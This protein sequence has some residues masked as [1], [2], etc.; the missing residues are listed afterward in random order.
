MQ[1]DIWDCVTVTIY[2]SLLGTKR[3]GSAF[4]SNSSSALMWEPRIIDEIKFKKAVDTHF[5]GGRPRGSN[6]F[7]VIRLANTDQALTPF[8]T[9]NYRDA[10]LVI[11]RGKSNTAGVSLS[12]VAS[13]LID[14]I[15]SDG[16]DVIVIYT[17][18]NSAKLEVAAQQNFYPTTVANRALHNR[19]RP[20]GFGKAFQCAPVE[21][22]LYGNRSYDIH[23]NEFFIGVDQYMDQGVTLAP[24]DQSYANGTANDLMNQYRPRSTISGCYGVDRLDAIRGRQVISAQLQS[25]YTTAVDH[26]FSA[27]TDWTET[28]GGVGG[29]DASISGGKL[30]FVN[31]TGG[32]DLYI[33]HNTTQTSSES[34]LWLCIIDVDSVT[35]GEFYVASGTSG[36]I[37]KIQKKGV[38]RFTFRTTANFAPYIIAYNGSNCS[39]VIN[40]FKLYELSLIKN[41][42]GIFA[43]LC[44]YDDAS[45]SG[46]GPLE[47]ASLDEAALNALPTYSLGAYYTEPVQIADV[48]DDV[49]QSLGGWWFI[50]N[51]GLL[52][53]AQLS[54]P[55]AGVSVYS[56]DESNVSSDIEVTP[57]TA[58]GLS[59]TILA[60]KNWTPYGQG[61]VAES[62]KYVQWNP[63][64]KDT[65]VTL[66]AEANPSGIENDASAILNVAAATSSQAGSVRSM[67]F[68]F[69]EKVYIEVAATSIPSASDHWRFGPAGRRAS[70]ASAPGSSQHSIGYGNSGVV[71]ANNNT[72]LSGKLTYTTG[73]TVS[74]VLD[75]RPCARGQGYLH[76]AALPGQSIGGYMFY[77]RNNSWNDSD[78]NSTE[79]ASNMKW[80]TPANCGY[81]MN[82]FNSVAATGSMTVNFGQKA[83]TYTPPDDCFLP[84]HHFETITSEYRYTYQSSSTIDPFYSQAE[85]YGT[86][87]E[88]KGTPT[89]ITSMADARTECERWITDLYPTGTRRKFYKFEGLLLDNYQDIQP[90]D[91]IDLTSSK[92]NLSALK[93]VVVEVEGNLIEGK[94]N[95]KGWA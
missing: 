92:L 8:L 28:N 38:H 40:S 67:P 83:L 60:L 6:T 25:Y 55:S 56:F 88:R 7:G 77:A 75:M 31:T 1:N 39:V 93:M 10:A 80:L 21:R 33:N 35:S 70:I 20:W 12:I 84:A 57:D 45:Y 11:A 62:L 34:K 2:F 27:L 14:R 3:Y 37:R 29:R 32:A 30:S 47:Y 90:G 9:T 91:I 63:L 61:E 43:H 15:E 42:L 73:Q 64:D 89:L 85:G 19:P 23:D 71:V 58:P 87:D 86:R 36:R 18:D 74:L 51:D 48:L 59:N 76:A 50:G 41:P 53:A 17:K 72:Y 78:P 49:M 26:T 5:W 65:H 22:E 46:R 44:T 16:E 68:Y 69:G 52:T 4:I 66:S 24:E 94:L 13:V 54:D 82:G 95:I 81:F 79:F